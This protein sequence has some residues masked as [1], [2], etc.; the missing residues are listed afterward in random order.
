M[1]RYFGTDGIRA[2]VGDEPM[3]PETVLKF[4]WAAGRA[5]CRGKAKALIGKDTRISG[6]MFESALEAGLSA[7]G[8]D[9]HLLGPL[10]TPGVAYLTLALKADLGFIIS[11]SHNLY[12]DNGI[13][14]FSAQGTK[15]SDEEETRVVDQMRQS[16][17][18]GDQLGKAYRVNDAVGRYTE[19]CK[20]TI[21]RGISFKGLR[22]AIDCAHGA[23]YTVAPQVFSELGATVFPIGINP[24]GFN[25]NADVGTL[26]P[27][28][29]RQTVLENNADV[30]IAL[31]GDGD[32]LILVDDKGD[33]VDGD[34]ILMIIAA[35]R[36]K[37]EDLYG[38][39]GTQMSNI[40]L[41][42][43]LTECGIVFERTQ[44]G[45]RYVME[46]LLEKGWQL[47]GETS[48]HVI[49][50]DKLPTGDGIIA[51][52]QVIQALIDEET[53]L[54]SA[55]KLMKK[56]PQKLV[57]MSCHA[58]FRSDMPELTR[59]TQAALNALGDYGRVVVRPSGTEPL[60][61]IMV[62][63]ESFSDCEKWAQEIAQVV[64]QLA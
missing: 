30:G 33:A 45:D 20:G 12:Y 21:R 43:S 61:R 25:I 3:T 4:G 49:C 52:L 9:V 23:A 55:R 18:I 35:H 13:K 53:C 48:G 8:V 60:V 63:A 26:H 34:E 44:V 2:R 40:G 29:L 16:L 14:L 11:A 24:D 28:T 41:E 32:R 15:L 59:V 38:V 1:E 27:D 39:V 7:A 19:F 10:S 58:T 50:L 22:I 42:R 62:E 5:L 36:L 51:A 56:Y 46:R 37:K 6:Y 54:S 57:N 64:K 47:G 17:Q 31:D